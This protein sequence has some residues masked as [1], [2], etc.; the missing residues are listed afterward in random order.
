MIDKY[1][2]NLNL[3]ED[4]DSDGVGDALLQRAPAKH[5]SESERCVSTHILQ[6]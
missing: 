5:P 6:M 3:P 1:S 4:D 2:K